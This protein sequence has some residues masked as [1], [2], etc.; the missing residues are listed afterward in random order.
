VKDEEQISAGN[1]HILQEEVARTQQK[2]PFF[3]TRKCK[4]LVGIFVL[5]LS[6][7]L[8]G[9]LIRTTSETIVTPSIPAT[10]SEATSP[11][12]GAEL[13]ERLRA[14]HNAALSGASV[15]P[16][17]R[18]DSTQAKILTW[19][20]SAVGKLDARGAVVPVTGTYTIP[21]GWFGMIRL[22]SD[23]KDIGS[24][25]V[26]GRALTAPATDSFVIT[27]IRQ[28]GEHLVQLSFDAV[29]SCRIACSPEDGLCMTSNPSYCMAGADNQSFLTY[30][31]ISAEALPVAGGCVEKIFIAGPKYAPQTPEDY[32]MCEKG[33]WNE[34]V[35]SGL[36][37]WQKNGL[38]GVSEARQQSMLKGAEEA[39][40]TFFDTLIT[41]GQKSESR[42]EVGGGAFVTL[43]YTPGDSAGLQP[44]LLKMQVRINCQQ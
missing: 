4:Y 21:A 9:V 6:M 27:P 13:T 33:M 25:L 18:S 19:S 20:A 7:F 5:L 38:P 16:R 23:G 44:C 3:C 41:Q 34:P 1:L 26:D 36:A 12:V 40:T 42:T 30:A 22:V 15:V 17:G 37:S 2:F 35:I 32:T 29:L 28:E 39:Y 8:F 24:V 31:P 11:V 43:S 14:L 10:L